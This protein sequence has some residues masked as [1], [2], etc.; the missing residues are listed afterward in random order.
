MASLG[1]TAGRSQGPELVA[2]ITV[3]LSAGAPVSSAH[4]CGSAEEPA[5][6]SRSTGERT[7]DLQ[8]C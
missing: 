7:R 3:S 8:T 2:R 4:P 5:A 1:L 6:S